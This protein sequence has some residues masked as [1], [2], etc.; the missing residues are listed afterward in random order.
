MKQ[1]GCQFPDDIFKCIFLNED[2]WISIKISLKFV[3]M[4][5]KN[6]IPAL[7]KIMAWHRE[8]DKPLSEPMMVSLLMHIFVTRPQWVKKKQLMALSQPNFIINPVHLELSHS[9]HSYQKQSKWKCEQEQS[10]TA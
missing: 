7:V 3:L 5:A 4:G 9:Y 2:V 10:E 8:G 6:D 1:N